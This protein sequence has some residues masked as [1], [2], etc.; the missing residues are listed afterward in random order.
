MTY[1]PFSGASEVRVATASRDAE[2]NNATRKSTGT[3]FVLLL[4]DSRP[5]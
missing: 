4:K 5:L 2:D 3:D 1:D